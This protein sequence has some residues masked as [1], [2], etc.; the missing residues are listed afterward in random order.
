M[1]PVDPAPPPEGGGRPRPAA[2][3][4]DFGTSKCCV[5]AVRD[6]RVDVLENELGQR[7]TPSCVAFNSQQRLVGSDALDQAVVN[8]ANTVHSV[9]SFLGR[10]YDEVKDCYSPCHIRPTHR[11]HRFEYVVHYKNHDQRLRPEQVA[12][13]LLGRMKDIAESSLGCSVDRAVISVPASFGNAQR[14]AVKYAAQVAGLE[15][16]E[17]INETTAAGVAFADNRTVKTP[18]VIAVVDFGAGKL[19][20]SIME[21]RDGSVRVVVAAGNTNLGGCNLDD[22]LVGHCVGVIHGRHNYRVKEKKQLE[23]LRIACEKAKKTLTLLPEAQFILENLFCNV[24]VSLTVKRKDLDLL[25][26]SDIRREVSSL[27]DHLLRQVSLAKD[28]ISKVVLVGGATRMPLVRAVL[29]EYFGPGKLDQTVNQDEAVAQGAALRAATLSGQESGTS[30]GVQDVTAFATIGDYSTKG[31]VDLYERIP[32]SRK[33]NITSSNSHYMRNLYERC[34]TGGNK[35]TFHVHYSR[36]QEF[37]SLAD[38]GFLVVNADAS[39]IL[40]VQAEVNGKILDGL[41]MCTNYYP[42]G[43]LKEWIDVANKFRKDVENEKNRV[44]AETQLESLVYEVKAALCDVQELVSR[45]EISETT[46]LCDVTLEWI[47]DAQA[48]SLQ[49]FNAQIEKLTQV[50]EKLDRIK[51]LAVEPKKEIGNSQNELL[52]KSKKFVEAK[53]KESSVNVQNHGLDSTLSHLSKNQFEEAPNSGDSD[54]KKANR[55]DNQF[56]GADGKILFSRTVVLNSIASRSHEATL[57]NA[58]IST[59]NNMKKNEVGG[60]TSFGGEPLRTC[61]IYSLSNDVEGSSS[62]IGS[63]ASD[64]SQYKRSVSQDGPDDR[65]SASRDRHGDRRSASRDGHGDKRSASRDGH[66]DRRSASRDGHGD[67]RSASRDGHG[68]RRSA[69]KDRNKDPRPSS[70]VKD[71]NFQ[72]A[73][74]DR[75]AIVPCPSERGRP[76]FKNQTIHSTRLRTRSQ[77]RTEAHELS[78]PRRYRSSSFSSKLPLTAKTSFAQGTQNGT[79]KNKMPDHLITKRS[80]VS[81][82]RATQMASKQLERRNAGSDGKFSGTFLSGTKES[83]LNNKSALPNKTSVNSMFPQLKAGIVKAPPQRPPSNSD[84]SACFLKQRDAKSQMSSSPKHIKSYVNTDESSE[85]NQ[86]TFESIS[87]NIFRKVPTFY[88]HVFHKIL[89]NPS[90]FSEFKDNLHRQLEEFLCSMKTEVLHPDEILGAVGTSSTSKH[91]SLWQIEGG[92]A[93]SFCNLSIDDNGD[94][95]KMEVDSP[96]SIDNMKLSTPRD[97][98]SESSRHVPENSGH[99]E[100][101]FSNGVLRPQYQ[102][103]YK[104]STPHREGSGIS[105][106]LRSQKS[107]LG[108]SRTNVSTL[109][110]SYETRDALAAV[111]IQ[112]SKKN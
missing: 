38:C 12:A 77:F 59:E 69:S 67:R 73:C 15:V 101:R 46:H 95:E 43:V 71:E 47:E 32:L 94:V 42:P 26:K 93:Q 48:A 78:R 66:G 111:E 62:R 76:L 79:E 81:T 6:G 105:Y 2:I 30:I 85:Y 36:S 107:D 103:V 17:L 104:D 21:V 25:I 18:A 16:L 61:E 3:G 19:D 34:Y 96:P 7:T 49:D 91:G 109:V 100:H 82:V 31:L 23:R 27:F 70:K 65:R 83:I 52:D 40:E 84:G 28:V 37:F 99:I 74:A 57:M 97:L 58:S 106:S 112:A 39:G 98:S 22:A 35:K 44:D 80:V 110:H 55:T 11:G 29:E 102:Q 20:V 33:I 13:M 89:S 4:I 87:Q 14:L 24:D 5:A 56:Y 63:E 64:G 9:K 50:R 1:P 92:L 72:C 53:S 75:D 54:N 41:V 86:P 60:Q 10:T 45:G 51:L 68:D 88:E 108:P 90:N 8:C